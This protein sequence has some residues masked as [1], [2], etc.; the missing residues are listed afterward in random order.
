MLFIGWGGILF[1]IGSW[2]LM[3]WLKGTWDRAGGLTCCG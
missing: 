3:L 2:D 1:C